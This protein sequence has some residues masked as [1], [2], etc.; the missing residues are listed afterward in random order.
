MF[1]RRT[2]RTRHPAWA[3]QHNAYTPPPYRSGITRIKLLLAFLLLVAI[4]VEIVG[5]PH[6][7][8]HTEG[9]SGVYWSVTGKPAIPIT[10]PGGRPPVLR[11]IKLNPSPL[12]H[13][14]RGAQWAWGRIQHA[15]VKH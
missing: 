1:H 14:G 13:A 2:N 10:A 8:L 15:V 4:A 12:D 11:M 3:G 9:G 7:R 5:V 6:V